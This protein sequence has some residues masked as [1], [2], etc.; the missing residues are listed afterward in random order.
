[1]PW[2]VFPTILL[3]DNE[4]LGTILY[5]VLWELPTRY[6]IALPML[7]SESISI[8]WP[9][10]DMEKRMSRYM[11]AMRQLD[12]HNGNLLRSLCMDPE[13]CV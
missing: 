13:F 10:M 9:N 12:K 5:N 1:M 3:Q 2:G 7:F 4:N 8:I 6:L 11:N